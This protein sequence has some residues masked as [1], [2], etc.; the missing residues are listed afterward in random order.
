MLMIHV[1]TPLHIS[2]AIFY[3]EIIQ[4]HVIYDCN[5][6]VIKEIRNGNSKRKKL[7][8]K[9]FQFLEFIKHS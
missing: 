6:T 2:R 4:M 5:Y 7:N 1:N 3:C 9:K 8:K